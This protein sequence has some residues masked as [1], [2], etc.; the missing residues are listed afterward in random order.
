MFECRHTSVVVFGKEIFY[1]QGI[2]ITLPGKSHVCTLTGCVRCITDRNELQHGNPHQIL[3]MGET[4]LDEDTF[5][6]YL[7]EMRDHYTADKVSNDLSC[8]MPWR[9]N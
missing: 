6:E 5:N 7:T 1:G 8:G 4:A 9:Q 2:N 3:D